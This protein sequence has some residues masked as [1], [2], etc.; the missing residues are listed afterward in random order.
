MANAHSTDLYYLGKGILSF[1]RLVSGVPEGYRDLGNATGFTITPALEKLEHFSSREGIKKKDKVVI[2]SAGLTA[3][4]T[5]DEYD[6]DN[7]ALALLGTHSGGVINLLSDPTIEGALRF[8]GAND[9]G[10]NFQ[11][12]LWK[13]ALQSTAEVPF[14]NE[15]WG[16]IPF[17]AEVQSDI[18]N[19]PSQEYGI[20][21]E[22]N[23]S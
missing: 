16:E 13:V 1:N 10:P 11:V 5:L 3:K 7:L 12:D 14:I 21:T 6:R 9:V 17:D 23:M 15:A 8:V 2:T 20:I 19:H 18:D 22:I 4:F